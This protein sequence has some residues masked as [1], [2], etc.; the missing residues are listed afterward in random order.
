VIPPLALIGDVHALLALPGG[1]HQRPVGIHD[2]P[3]EKALGLAP[4]DVQADLVDG[5]H[6]ALHRRGIETPTEV[7]GRGRVGNPLGPQPIQV[8]LV[9]PPQFQ[10][11]QAVAP[12]Q[13]IEGDVKH[14]VR[15]VIRLMHLQQL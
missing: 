14:V 2:R 7:P 11:L 15:L 1:A 9:V 6:Q 4:P 5:L 8:S 12:G 10:I 3:R 13:K